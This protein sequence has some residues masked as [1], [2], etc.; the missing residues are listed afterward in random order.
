MKIVKFYGKND[1]GMP[2]N[3]PQEIVLNHP[4]NEPLPPDFIILS[5][6]EIEQ[7]IEKNKDQVEQ[8]MQIQQEKI[9]QEQKEKEALKP[10]E[11]IVSS[12]SALTSEQLQALKGLINA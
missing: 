3:H 5:D 6:E 1:L 7:R 9:E 10:V 8:A 12:I 4:D 11:D 2:E